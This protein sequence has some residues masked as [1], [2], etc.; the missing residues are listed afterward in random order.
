MWDSLINQPC[1]IIVARPTGDYDEG[2][3]P[4]YVDDEP[5]ETRCFVDWSR[6]RLRA[7][8]STNAELVDSSE[9]PIVLPAGTTIT[10]RSRIVVAGVPWH[11]VGNPADQWDPFDRA[12]AFVEVFCSQVTLPA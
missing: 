12:Q 8:A 3:N 7:G 11:V 9:V 2:N 1:T 10:P 5:V 6:S 4:T